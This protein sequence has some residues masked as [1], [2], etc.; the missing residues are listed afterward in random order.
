MVAQ[1]VAV[2]PSRAPA[3]KAIFWIQLQE[4]P[5]RPRGDA[6]G[7]IAVPADGM[8]TPDVRERYADRVLKRLCARIPNL[9][10][11]IVGRKVLSP[12]DLAALNINLVGGDPYSGSCALDQFLLWRPLAGLRGHRTPV[13]RLYHIGASTHPGPGLGGMSGFMVANALT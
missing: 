7:E 6:A 3:G 11:S 8:W 13:R 9:E 1:P 2:D 5:S 10:K 12:A 4:L